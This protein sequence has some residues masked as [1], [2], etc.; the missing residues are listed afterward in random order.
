MVGSSWISSSSSDSEITPL[1][2]MMSGILLG[3]SSFEF[4]GG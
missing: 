3:S 4:S 2:D 1:S